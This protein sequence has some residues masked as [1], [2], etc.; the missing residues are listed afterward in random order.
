MTSFDYEVLRTSSNSMIA[1]QFLTLKDCVPE[2]VVTEDLLTRIRR[3]CLPPY[4]FSIWLKVSKSAYVA[5]L[6]VQQEFSVLVRRSGLRHV[7]WLLEHADF[8]V[9]LDNF[10]EASQMVALF[11]IL[12]VEDV[13]IFSR[14]LSSGSRRGSAQSKKWVSEIC[15]TLLA[16][17]GPD[18]RPISDFYTPMLSICSQDDVSELLGKD[19]RFDSYSS[20]LLLL[21]H[22]ALFQQK[23]A[24]A[25]FSDKSLPSYTEDLLHRLP[26][27]VKNEKGLTPSMEFSMKILRRISSEAKPDIKVKDDFFFSTL[28]E[29][30]ANRVYKNDGK[31]DRNGLML[32][33]LKHVATFISARPKSI[34]RISFDR[35]R[36]IGWFAVQIWSR[37]AQEVE[38]IITTFIKAK[39]L[40]SEQGL[41]NYKES[42]KSIAVNERFHFLRILLQSL[43]TDLDSVESLKHSV[44][45][46]WPRWL[47]QSLKKNEALGLFSRLAT[48]KADCFLSRSFHYPYQDKICHICDFDLPDNSYLHESLLLSMLEKGTDDALLSAAKASGEQMRKAET[49]REHADRAI[50]AKG[51]LYYAMVSGSL[52]LLLKTINWTK[53]F[54]RDPFVMPCLVSDD[55]VE[56]I[57]FIDMLV[58]IPAIRPLGNLTRSETN[59]SVA[60]TAK[61]AVADIPLVQDILFSLLSLAFSSLREPFFNSRHWQKVL[62]L[63]V[64][65][66]F[67]RVER[68][69]A[70][71]NIDA[72]D[73]KKLLDAIK[74][75]MLEYEKRCLEL[76]DKKLSYDS[77]TWID[78]ALKR[79][80]LPENRASN[81]ITLSFLDDLAK[82]RDV[83][84]H[85][86][87][88]K[89]NPEIA[90]LQPPYSRGLPLIKHLQPFHRIVPYTLDLALVKNTE[91]PPYIMSRAEE[92]VFMAGDVALSDFP[93]DEETAKAILP[94]FDS[95]ALALRVYIMGIE[96]A[97][98]PAAILEAWNH[99]NSKLTS[100]N[101]GQEKA[102]E[103]WGLLFRG[104]LG[105]MA[106]EVLG[107]LLVY[108]PVL[109]LPSMDDSRNQI[110]WDPLNAC[111]PYSK[112]REVVLTTIGWFTNAYISFHQGEMRS[113]LKNSPLRGKPPK[114]V[115]G[116]SSPIWHNFKDISWTPQNEANIVSAILYLD[117][118][119]KS[120]RR[121][122][123]ETYPLESEARYHAMFLDESFLSRRDLSN[124]S[125][126][127]AI[128][129]LLSMVPPELLKTLTANAEESLNTLSPSSPIVAD[130]ERDFFVLLKL[131]MRSD[132][133][134]TAASLCIKTIIGRPEA[135]SWHRQLLS[136]AIL[137]RL[138]AKE[139]SKLLQH[140]S[141]SILAALEVQQES[142][143]SKNASVTG[144]IVKITTIKFL[145]ELLRGSKFVNLSFTVNILSRLIAEAKHID[146]RV[147]CL[148]SLLQ[149]LNNCKEDECRPVA[150]D[151]LKALTSLTGAAGAL[152]EAKQLSEEEWEKAKIEQKLPAPL[153][154]SNLPPIMS[155]LMSA[156]KGLPK[157]CIIT[158]S[159]F[160]SRVI[161]PMFEQ[162]HESHVRWMEIFCYKYGITELKNV[163]PIVPV[164]LCTTIDVYH[165]SLL[166]C[167]PASWF[168]GVHELFMFTLCPPTT[169]RAVNRKIS[170]RK[171]LKSGPDGYWLRHYGQLPSFKLVKL[172]DVCVP[173]ESPNGVTLEFVQALVLKE[174]QTIVQAYDETKDP[175]EDLVTSLTCKND[176]KRQ[177]IRWLK[178][179]RPVVEQIISYIENVRTPKWMKDV[180]RQPTAL[181]STYRLR[182][183][184]IEF[185]GIPSES[186]AN[187]SD[188]Y[189]NLAKGLRDF[190]DIHV[191]GVDETPYH[192]RFEILKLYVL[193]RINRGESAEVANSLGR[194]TNTSN[195]KLCDYLLIE[196]TDGLLLSIQKTLQTPSNVPEGLGGMVN[197][198]AQCGNEYIRSFGQAW[199]KH[200]SM[201]WLKKVAEK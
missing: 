78:S 19:A 82:S 199:V 29:H 161:I 45:K 144:V 42:F 20:R 117:A 104:A 90:A 49:S 196:L 40:A 22:T 14:S 194:V 65:I 43:G 155:E 27:G 12:S 81:P 189:D 9:I 173:L 197:E 145:T 186:S 178:Q 3:G 190:I 28:V 193:K 48:A 39:S 66:A 92:L 137:R 93:K 179:K 100:P 156:A 108:D 35:K 62:D 53:R 70:F 71:A 15:R 74:N 171:D 192:K 180:N 18:T 154:S 148:K 105:R 21:E 8:Q 133:P 38:G 191:I 96:N 13:K 7:G 86:Y 68:L 83:I 157:D 134:T 98:R 85:H 75:I 162:S 114:S 80:P 89:E 116:Y 32:E 183:S 55:V 153:I 125:A 61:K 182:L 72:S 141:S 168:L 58:G 115:I 10:G 103:E 73:G 149:V 30:L 11:Q 57:E 59:K 6:A 200:R 112:E 132:R 188:N 121:I 163:L 127:N 106:L 5:R 87:R 76:P 111:P 34:S 120:S 67:L 135:S 2:S 160:M 130:R 52:S 41:E 143:G 24:K 138:P 142:R 47:F 169:V 147:A 198:W 107:P 165:E 50:Y 159:S 201:P 1:E 84:W 152:N 175:W 51:A 36:N 17:H 110:E 174:A 131:L 158:Q 95:Y 4:I 128:A 63:P 140:F 26:H 88:I 23:V 33:I 25:I 60:Q 118:Q 119:F 172:L 91:C 31:S 16:T 126:E 56:R 139:A 146:V 54:I 176:G 37:S 185:P 94:F 77:E 184:L 97:S 44:I 170:N 129:E 195:A 177:K 124:Q 164:N 166:H 99:A 187:K 64:R 167:M 123:T 181:P 46:K 136:T 79:S 122:L 151:V 101:I 150:E 109:A 69:Q 113:R 102:R